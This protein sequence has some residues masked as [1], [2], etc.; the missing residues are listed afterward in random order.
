MKIYLCVSSHISQGPIS[1]TINIY[2]WV[3]LNNASF[4]ICS[5]MWETVCAVMSK[6][7]L[8]HPRNPR[9]HHDITIVCN[10]NT[11]PW[12]SSNCTDLCIDASI[13]PPRSSCTMVYIRN[14]V[15][16]VIMICGVGW[17]PYR[18]VDNVIM[19]TLRTTWVTSGKYSDWW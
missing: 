9:W 2:F 15:I 13:P 11:N 4:K 16:Y 6:T 18:L 7:T 10:I 19:I 1:R 14:F 12:V 3:P 17:V 5:N 8:K